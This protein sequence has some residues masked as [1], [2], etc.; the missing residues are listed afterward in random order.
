M[1]D[2]KMTEVSLTGGV[3]EAK[4]LGATAETRIEIWAQA[5]Q[6]GSADCV[7]VE[8]GTVLRWA[9]PSDLLTL[10]VQSIAFAE[11]DQP[12][13]YTLLVR[14]GTAVEGDLADDVALLRAE[15]DLLKSAF[16]RHCAETSAG[17]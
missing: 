13:I 6:V 7:A 15:L 5:Q 1:P 12:P 11:R 17:S 16:R 4:L 3:F 9:V 14:A 8:G 10:G 2:L